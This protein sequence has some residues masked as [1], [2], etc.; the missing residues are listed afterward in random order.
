MGWCGL[1]MWGV[2]A[3]RDVYYALATTYL[4]ECFS[5]DVINDGNNTAPCL[6]AT[7]EYTGQMWTLTPWP[8]GT[9]RLTNGFTGPDTSLDTYGD[10]HDPWLNTGD[11][12][13][14]HW[15]LTSAGP[16]PGTVP[17][18]ALDPKGAVE[19]TEGP[20]DFTRFARPLGVVRAVLIFVDFSDAPAG[21]ASAA[22]AADHLL[23]SGHAQPLYLDQSYGRLTPDVTVRSDLGWRRLPTSS[24][25]YDLRIFES[26]RSY[27][28]AAAV[29]FHP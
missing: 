28:I 1:C 9:Y 4:G 19:Q 12:T 22:A 3:W 27:I 14:Q 5:P 24:T 17:I 21:P 18:P 11:H 10:T 15:T 25:S 2:C 23:G 6:A 7:G 26:Q 20:T 16:V 13:G 29:P 8:D